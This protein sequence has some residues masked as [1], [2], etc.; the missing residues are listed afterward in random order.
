MQASPR[1]PDPD[2]E[3]AES[4]GVFRQALDEVGP[5]DATSAPLPLFILGGLFAVLLIAGGLGYL[6]RRGLPSG[7]RLGRR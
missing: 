4:G 1:A 6:V 7:L 2:E 3:R 5:E